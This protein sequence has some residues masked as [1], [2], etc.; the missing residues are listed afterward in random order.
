ML[1]GA[2]RELFAAMT[3]GGRQRPADLPV[4]VGQVRAAASIVAFTDALTVSLFGLGP[5]GLPGPP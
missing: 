4:V 3:V 2:Y 1:G 5:A